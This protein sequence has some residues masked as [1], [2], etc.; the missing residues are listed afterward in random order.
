MSDE[1]DKREEQ[2]IES[3]QETENVQMDTIEQIDDVPLSEEMPVLKKKS[4]TVFW[5]AAAVVILAAVIGYKSGMFSGEKLIDM[6]VAYVKDDG[7]FIDDLKNP[8]YQGAESL[9]SGGV[10]SYYYTAWGV[11]VSEDGKTI[12]YSDN[13]GEDGRFDLYKR[14]VAPGGEAELIASGVMNYQIS[15]DGSVCAYLKGTDEGNIGLYAT[16]AK[17]EVLICK[18][19]VLSENSFHLSNDGKQIVYETVQEDGVSA[20]AAN[21]VSGNEEMILTKTLVQFSV[22][23]ETEKIYYVGQED[24]SYSIYE[25]TFGQEPVLVGKNAVAMEVLGNNKDVMFAT[26][27]SIQVDSQNIID[28]DMAQADAQI[29]TPDFINGT[30]EEKKAYDEK[31]ARDE[32]RL[33]LA[34]GMF[35]SPMQDLF[36]WSEGKAVTVDTEILNAKAV[37]GK[38]GY[39]LYSK[40]DTSA[41]PKVKLSSVTSLDEAKYMYYVNLSGAP[42]NTYFVKAGKTPLSLEQENVRSDSFMVSENGNRIAYDIVDVLTGT[43]KFYTSELSDEGVSS[44]KTE[45]GN[46][47]QMSEFSGK[48]ENIYWLEGADQAMQEG[49]LMA[50]EN[51]QTITV[52][53]KVGGFRVAEDSQA[54]YYINDILPQ[55]GNGKLNMFVNGSST[56]IDKDVFCMQY[57]NN[58]NVVYMK[59][60]DMA[61]EMGDLYY[62]NGKSSR[63]IDKGVSSIFIY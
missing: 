35:E 57:K 27:S 1:N 48:G 7:L 4:N 3:E 17:T 38:D 21:A 6:P 63:L 47:V 44:E 11:I 16:A 58:G 8:P 49:K 37:I 23:K 62:W 59:N 56:E 5:I 10:Y 19:A 42:R 29:S 9:S 54:V 25:Y 12:Y 55:T 52:S 18:N 30:E 14:T 36:I 61:T 15:G 33:A 60:Y 43:S 34:D 39:M 28:D 24:E 45:L 2:T 46:N 13:I 31:A 26:Q 22:A 41:L 53:E 51:G 50:F 20:L 32:V 40:I